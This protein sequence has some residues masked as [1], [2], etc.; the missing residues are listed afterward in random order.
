MADITKMKIPALALIAAG[1]STENMISCIEAQVKSKLEEQLKKLSAPVQEDTHAAEWM[2]FDSTLRNVGANL[3]ADLV[4]K[5]N[6]EKAKGD[7]AS[8]VLLAQYAQGIEALGAISALRKPLL[9]FIAAA[10]AESKLGAAL[11]KQDEIKKEI[12]RLRSA[13]AVTK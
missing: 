13:L 4:N 6:V 8:P 7:N 11:D 9:P 1:V 3:V 2:R 10:Q 12:E 5:V